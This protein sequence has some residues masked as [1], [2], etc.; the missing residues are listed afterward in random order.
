MVMEYFCSRTTN[1]EIATNI[2]LV[3]PT[4]ISVIYSI[5]YIKYKVYI[6]RYSDGYQ[7]IRATS[8]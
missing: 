6:I 2:N 5:K 1:N 8:N 7:D 4:I 3:S